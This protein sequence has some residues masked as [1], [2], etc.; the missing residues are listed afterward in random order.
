MDIDNVWQC[1]C[2]H[3]EHGEIPPEDCAKCLRVNKFK[4]VPADLAE[5]AAAEEILSTLEE[6]DE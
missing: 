2:G 5:E 6:E 3:I 1:K 4:K